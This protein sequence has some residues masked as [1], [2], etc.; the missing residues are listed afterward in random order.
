M[1]TK[2]H[3]VQTPKILHEEI[4][5]VLEIPYF[6][7]DCAA[8]PHNSL[9]QRF[10]IDPTAPVEERKHPSCVGVN[11]KNLRVPWCV[12]GRDTTN[13]WLFPPWSPKETQFLLWMNTA[14]AQIE[15]AHAA[16]CPLN[17]HICILGHVWLKRFLFRASALTTSFNLFC[18]NF[19]LDAD[20][21]VHPGR[22]TPLRDET[23]TYPI[24][25]PICDYV[26]VLSLSSSALDA[27]LR[28]KDIPV[29]IR[30]LEFATNATPTFQ[31]G[32]QTAAF[33][34]QRGAPGAKSIAQLDPK[35]RPTNPVIKR[36][37]EQQEKQ[38]K[39]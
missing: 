2:I 16:G 14:H 10:I 30:Q 29:T 15:N 35:N 33:T 26:A 23:L 37:L 5:R 6:D 36:I 38:P 21:L 11:A 3:S 34:S 24:T 12:M 17:V 39:L 7:I 13:A 8:R 32:L 27:P 25:P 28:P 19:L 4:L 20:P 1:P 18:P 9:A 31:P 22:D